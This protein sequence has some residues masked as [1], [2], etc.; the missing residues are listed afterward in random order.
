MAKQE[1]SLSPAAIRII[2]EILSRGGRV[3]ISLIGQRLRINRVNSK[4]E[5]DVMIG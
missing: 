4:V 3:E 1:V 2:N 5:Y